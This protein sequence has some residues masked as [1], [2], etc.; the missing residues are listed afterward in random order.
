VEIQRALIDARNAIERTALR[1]ANR[2]S[3]LENARAALSR[4]IGL[5]AAPAGRGGLA[6]G[7]VVTA[8][9]V[10]AKASLERSAT[11]LAGALAP[12]QRRPCADAGRDLA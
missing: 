4:F 2:I 11:R 9:L 1:L 5:A 12:L 6:P 3:E 10:A 7:D 8:E